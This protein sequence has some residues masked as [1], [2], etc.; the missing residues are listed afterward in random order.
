M[1][2]VI[3]PSEEE[4]LSSFIAEAAE[5][6]VPI[7]VFG[8]GSKRDI[9]RP[10]QVEATVSSE[11]LTGITLYEPSELV[12]SAGS[13]T[14][15]AD[16]EEL[17]HQYNQQLPFEPIDLGPVLKGEAGQ[18]TLGAVF[19]TNLSGPRRIYAGSARDHLIGMRAINGRGELF[20]SGGRVMK[21]VTGYDLSRTLTGSWGTLAVM[22]EVTMKVLPIAEETRTL[23]F[24]D[25]L[26]EIA[27]N[28]MCDAVITP[29]EISATVHIDRDLVSQIAPDELASMGKSITAIR[30]ENFS[31]S[32]DYRI[33]QLRSQFQSY[34]DIELL[35]DAQ[36][37]EFWSSIRQLKFLQHSHDPVWRISTLPKNAAEII[38]G[39][40]AHHPQCSAVYEWSGGLIWLLMPPL[41]DAGTSEVRR[42]VGALGGHATLIRS[43]VSTRASVEVFHPLQKGPMQLTQQLKNV[44]DPAGILNP[45]RMYPGI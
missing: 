24:F 31:E 37:L 16:V 14:P 19:A 9:G 33:D 32:L 4:E 40:R 36:S 44:F 27:I 7:E 23:L 18:G 15:L 42:S 30:L 29:Y 20:K 35:N 45:G 2:H 1:A 28:L 38:R 21:N 34:G 6:G 22:T 12:L 8:A 17:L 11:N 13:G 3:R 25:L 39:I 5:S 41:S 10:L 26:D 43:D